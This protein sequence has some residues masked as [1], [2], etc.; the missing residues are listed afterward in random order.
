MSSPL[1]PTN[2][3]GVPSGTTP[4]VAPTAAAG[5]TATASVVAGSLDQRGAI[6]VASAGTGQAAGATATVTFAKP[7]AANIVPQVSLTPMTAA[8]AALNDFVA[9]VTNTGFQIGVGTAMTAATTYQFGYV[10]TP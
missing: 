9:T 2:Q 7:L 6:S 5:T 1:G 4:T 3:T 10:V 8:T